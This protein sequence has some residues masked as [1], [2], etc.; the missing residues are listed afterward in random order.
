MSLNVLEFDFENPVATMND[1]EVE[2][3]DQNVT[4]LDE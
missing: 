2:A 4:V 1:D 3:H